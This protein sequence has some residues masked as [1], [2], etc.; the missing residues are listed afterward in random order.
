MTIYTIKS[1]YSFGSQVKFVSKWNGSGEGVII[2]IALNDDSSIYYIIQLHS[3]DV[4]GGIL[5]DDIQAEN[6]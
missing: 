2:G 3:G 5:P 4:V 1:E 6:M